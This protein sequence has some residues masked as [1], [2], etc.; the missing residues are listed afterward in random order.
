MVSNSRVPNDILTTQSDFKYENK[1]DKL[2][3]KMT[4]A[5]E[6]KFHNGQKLKER[7]DVYDTFIFT[8]PSINR[9]DCIQEELIPNIIDFTPDFIGLKTGTSSRKV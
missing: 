2:I 9:K 5:S 4:L 8:N 3:D 1:I 6:Y 7:T